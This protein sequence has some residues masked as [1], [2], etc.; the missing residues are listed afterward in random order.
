MRKWSITY[1][2]TSKEG[3]TNSDIRGRHGR[4]YVNVYPKSGVGIEEN[5]LLRCEVIPKLDGG[6]DG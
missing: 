2:N 1:N 6:T 3:F 4:I 5:G